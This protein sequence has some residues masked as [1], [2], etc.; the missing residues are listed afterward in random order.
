M[1]EQALTSKWRFALLA[2]AF[3]AVLT[4]ALLRLLRAYE[5]Y[6]LGGE[7]L[8]VF[9]LQFGKPVRS[10]SIPHFWAQASFLPVWFTIMAATWQMFQLRLAIFWTFMTIWF[11]VGTVRAFLKAYREPQSSE[12]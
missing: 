12:N 6:L 3:A 1:P 4:F 11:L 9:V 5:T 7:M 8:L 10:E 2:V